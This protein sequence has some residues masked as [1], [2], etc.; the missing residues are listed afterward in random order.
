MTMSNQTYI[1]VTGWVTRDPELRRTNASQTPVCTIRLG[2]ASRWPDR[3]TGEWREGPASYYDVV[4][5]RSLAVN[6][7][8]SL[9]KGQM[10]TV[11]GTFR[12]RA[13]TDRENRPRTSLE[14]VANSV[15]HD[16]VYGWSH[17]NRIRP[18]SSGAEGESAGAWGGRGLASGGP[19]QEPGMEF[20]ELGQEAG[21]DAY[22]PDPLPGLEPSGL[23]RGPGWESDG[24][25]EEFGQSA[26]S[27][28]GGAYE[29]RGYESDA[30]ESGAAEDSGF[31][32]ADADLAA[33]P[34]FGPD[35]GP[36]YVPGGEPA[37]PRVFGTGDGDGADDAGL[38]DA[39]A[40]LPRLAE[41]AVPV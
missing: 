16:L 17:Y 19:G 39:V 12:N 28:F 11:H 37:G 34:V 1:K 35:G 41:A 23:G 8:A 7:S 40:D 30:D 24:P 2:T 22:G 27:P 20:G 9:R 38:P 33:G 25:D 4:C 29:S 36:G 6:V 18:S 10:V 5:W 3:S 13:W 15:G 31:E 14:I 32:S 21:L 26:A